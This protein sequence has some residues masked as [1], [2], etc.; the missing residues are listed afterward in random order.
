M[1]TLSAN[2]CTAS[3]KFIPS[4]L[5]KKCKYVSSY[6][7]TKTAMEYLLVWWY[8]KGWW[9]SLWNGHS[10]KKFLPLLFKCICTYCDMISTMSF[11]LSYFYLLFHHYIVAFFLTFFPFNFFK[12]YIVI[13]FDAFYINPFFLLYYLFLLYLMYYFPRDAKIMNISFYYHISIIIFYFR[14]ISS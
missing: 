11:V 1:L 4:I 5:L 7:T 2:V 14:F 8:G 9:F 13:L 10:P 12:L 6:S 3:I